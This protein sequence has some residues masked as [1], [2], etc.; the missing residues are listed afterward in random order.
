VEKGDPNAVRLSV[1]KADAYLASFDDVRGAKTRP[2]E[3]VA[4]LRIELPRTPQ[5]D[6]NS[7]SNDSG[8][9]TRLR[10]MAFA[11]EKAIGDAGTAVEPAS[12]LDLQ[13]IVDEAVATAALVTPMAPTKMRLSAQT[14]SRLNQLFEM[15]FSP[16]HS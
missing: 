14:T 3:L 4:A 5:A 13:K 9:R 16:S 6:Q 2:D 8:S 7:R 10:R 12:H 15:N 11:H 1:A